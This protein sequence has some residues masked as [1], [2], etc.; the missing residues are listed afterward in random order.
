[1]SVSSQ[2]YV[3]FS[4]H[5]D[6]IHSFQRWSKRLPFLFHIQ[7]D[8]YIALWASLE[9]CLEIHSPPNVSLA[10]LSMLWAVCSQ[11]LGLRL[12]RLDT[13]TLLTGYPPAALECHHG[14]I[15]CCCT[16]SSSK[17]ILTE[18]TCYSTTGTSEAWWLDGKKDRTDFQVPSWIRANDVLSC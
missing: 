7:L 15:Y 1:M 14:I 17:I 16:R 12:G 2:T 10:L 5:I 3:P 8:L 9:R 13:G 4:R 11:A 18:N 6:C